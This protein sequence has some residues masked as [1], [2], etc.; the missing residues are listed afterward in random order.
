MATSLANS[1]VLIA[2]TYQLASIELES[3]SSVARSHGLG[4]VQ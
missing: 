1:P 4:P 3:A 2:P